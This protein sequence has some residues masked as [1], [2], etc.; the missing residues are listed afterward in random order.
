[1]LLLA[2]L[3]PELSVGQDFGAVTCRVVNASGQGMHGQEVCLGWED[4]DDKVD[5]LS[6][7]LAQLRWLNPPAYGVYGKC[8]QNCTAALTSAASNMSVTPEQELAAS[9]LAACQRN[10]VADSKGFCNV[11]DRHGYTSILG[12][13]SQ[14]G[15]RSSGMPYPIGLMRWR[16]FVRDPYDDDLFLK[17]A[18]D[19]GNAFARSFWTREFTRHQ[20]LRQRLGRRVLHPPDPLGVRAVR[21]RGG[22]AAMCRSPD[23]W[24]RVS[25]RTNVRF[26]KLSSLTPKED[27]PSPL[28]LPNEAILIR[29]GEFATIDLHTTHVET[30]I[31]VAA[32]VTR[33]Q[34]IAVPSLPVLRGRHGM[35]PPD[36]SITSPANATFSLE[37]PAAKTSINAALLTA[38]RAN[39]VCITGPGCNKASILRSPPQFY[40]KFTTSH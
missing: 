29:P 15:V 17:P 8:L 10:A 39:R 23:F 6:E 20:C 24:T 22:G 25:L 1:M 38:S 5:G 4:V 21:G 9:C 14:E 3:P 40:A 26:V 16:L 30:G 35:W 13:R 33:A 28:P 11:T 2:P 12:V 19:N 7:A 18:L 27:Q 32:H 31:G 34:V 37:V 36:S